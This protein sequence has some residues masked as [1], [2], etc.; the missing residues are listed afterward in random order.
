M[1]IPRA[2]SSFSLGIRAVVDRDGEIIVM[3]DDMKQISAFAS[4]PGT[5]GEMSIVGLQERAASRKT[6]TG[7][8]LE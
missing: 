3:K 7:A 4:N 2:T 8:V 1:L 6:E 5:G